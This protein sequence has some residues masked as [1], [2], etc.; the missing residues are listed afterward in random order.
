MTEIIAAIDE[1]AA[2]TFL[3]TVIGALP[4]LSDSGSGNLG[5]FVAS[6]SVSATVSVSLPFSDFVEADADFR[7]QFGLSG[8][9][10]NVS[11]VVVGL[12]T[13]R[14][15]I[16]TGALLAAIGLAL[17]PVLLA[18]PFIGPLLG[19]ILTP[20][21]SGIVIPIHSVPQLFEMLPA[22]GPFDPPV[23]FNSYRIVHECGYSHAFGTAGDYRWTDAYGSGLSGAIR[24]RDPDC[25]TDSD[26]KRWRE[27]LAEGTLVTITDSKADQS[28]LEIL[29][30]QTIFFLVVTGPGISI[31]DE[32]LIEIGGYANNCTEAAASSDR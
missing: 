4:A 10:W 15:G 8:G 9:M 3:G 31:T 2:N 28:E 21:I 14:F 24:V 23:N 32:R 18:I 12:P 1:G 17:T 13:L 7:L 22:E 5:P 6:Y 27:A 19:P 11:A 30:G 26:L 16:A 20:F 29:V 25:R